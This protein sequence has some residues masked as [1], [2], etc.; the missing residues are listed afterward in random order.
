MYEVKFTVGGIGRLLPVA[1]SLLGLGLFVIWTAAAHSQVT[2][3]AE[4]QSDPPAAQVESGRKQFSQSCAFCHGADATGGRGADLVRSTLVAHDQ[5]GDLIGEVIRNGRPD[6]GMPALPATA[7]QIADIAAF[8][9]ARAREAI[10]SSGVPSDYPVEKLLTGNAEAGKA[11][12]EG[13]GGCKNCH[14]VTGDLAG[15][16]KKYSSIEFEARMLYPGKQ[17]KSAVVTLPSGDQVRGTV[18]HEDDFMI[19]VRDETGWYR[20]FSRDKVKVELQDPL[21]AHRTL[22]DKLTQKDV[23]NLFAYVYSLK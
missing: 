5:K 20:S 7:E 22:L 3:Q 17:H 9:H 11:F 13:P 2:P 6:K 19:G 18:V 4:P 14:S 8:L 10:R 1:A 16:A 23:R 15:L 12:F 21:A